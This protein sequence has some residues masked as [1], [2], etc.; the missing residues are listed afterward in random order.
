M[1]ESVILFALS[2]FFS[3]ISLIHDYKVSTLDRF[4]S[5]FQKYIIFHLPVLKTPVQ[6]VTNKIF[7]IFNNFNRINITL[8][9]LN[10]KS[11]FKSMFIF[12]VQFIILF[13]VLLSMFVFSKE[14]FEFGSDVNNID[15]SNLKIQFIT[16]SLLVLFVVGELINTFTKG[17]KKLKQNIEYLFYTVLYVILFVFV[18]FLLISKMSGNSKFEGTLSL[19]K[20][21]PGYVLTKL[22]PYLLDIVDIMKMTGM[23]VLI[24]FLVAFYD[25]AR[26]NEFD[27]NENKKRNIVYGMLVMFIV[28]ISTFILQ[29][30]KLH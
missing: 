4:Q 15:Q 30:S 19:N 23:S 21:L 6:I 5:F 14:L 9:E 7:N 27:E 16:M 3:I 12:Q 2:I 29:S 22:E 25:F 10:N 1:I 13:L 17:K 11:Y 18:F 8:H 20:D 24:I 28:I 26:N